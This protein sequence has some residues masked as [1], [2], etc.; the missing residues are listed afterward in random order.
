MNKFDLEKKSVKGKLFIPG[1]NSIE[2]FIKGNVF[3]RKVSP[4]FTS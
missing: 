4:S 2:V 1:N 3:I